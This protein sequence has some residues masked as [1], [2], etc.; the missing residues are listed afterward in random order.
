VQPVKLGSFS[1]MSDL[2]PTHIF[3][4]MIIF[5]HH[6]K[7]FSSFQYFFMFFNNFLILE[8]I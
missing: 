5:L 1:D 2:P 3:L 6:G 8:F 7:S 4:L